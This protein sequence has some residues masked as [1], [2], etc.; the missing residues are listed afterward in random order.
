MNTWVAS[1]FWLL[2]IMLLWTWVY[3]YLFE[4]LL[5]I[6]LDIYSEVELLDGVVILCLIFW[7]TIILFSTVAAPFYIP[8]RNA[9]GFPFHPHQHL[10]FSGLFFVFLIITT[11]KSMK[12]YYIVILICIS[13]LY[14]KNLLFSSPV[15]L[16]Y[17]HIEHFTFDTSG[18]QMCGGG[19]SP[20]QAI[21]CDTSWVS[22]SLTQFWHY[23]PGDSIKFTG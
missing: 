9:Q 11:L 6:L 19:F 17:F 21:L 18:H 10:L 20:Q 1:T 15:C 5:L 4:S 13:V 8:T 3:K 12:W 22:Y 16:L 23:L 7:E 14:W 2:W